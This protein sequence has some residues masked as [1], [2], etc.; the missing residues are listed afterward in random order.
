[1]VDPSFPYSE[2]LPRPGSARGVQIDIDGANPSPRH[3]MEVN[4]IGGSAATLRAL[5]P[6]LQQQADLSWRHK[7]EGDVASW[8]KLLENRAMQ[9]ADPVNPRRVPREL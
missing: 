4:L 7:I 9:S 2:F 6:I 3:P 8:W 5:L 1:M